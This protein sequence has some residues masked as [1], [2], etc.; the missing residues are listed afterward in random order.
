MIVAHFTGSDTSSAALTFGL[1][2]L[3]L[4]VRDLRGGRPARRRRA[5]GWVVGGGTLLVLGLVL[6]FTHAGVNR[7]PPPS[8]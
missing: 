6:G 3:L 7:P 1:A 4:G 5:L 2:L 8:P